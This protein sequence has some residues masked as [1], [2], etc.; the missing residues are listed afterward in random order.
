MTAHDDVTAF[1]ARRLVDQESPARERMQVE[2][3]QGLVRD[4]DDD[5]LGGDFR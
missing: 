5:V 2:P 3:Q 4:P 1:R